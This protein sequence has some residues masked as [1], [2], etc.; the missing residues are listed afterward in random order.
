MSAAPISLKLL[1]QRHSLTRIFTVWGVSSMNS[2]S[3]AWAKMG[4]VGSMSFLHASM[5]SSGG[6]SRALMF[7]VA[8]SSAHLLII[9]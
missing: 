2:V 1:A 3:K 5:I 8:S 6:P 7:D 9:W 4:E